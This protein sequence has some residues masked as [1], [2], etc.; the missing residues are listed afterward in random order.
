MSSISPKDVLNN[1]FGYEDFRRGQ[2][3]IIDALLNGTNVLGV[4]PTGSGKSLC[5]QLPSLILEGATIVV[6]PLIALMQDQIDALQKKNI[7]AT[8]I[9]S[10]V[11]RSEQQ[12]RIKL[13]SQGKLDLVY[14]APERFQDER[15]T[16]ALENI[17]VSLL[18]IDEAHCISQ[19]GHDF[20]PDYLEL[21]EIR[22]QLGDPTTIALTATATTLVKDDI[23]TQLSLE[24]PKRVV[25]GFERPNLFFEVYRSQGRR[26]KMQRIR[27]LLEYYHGES[28]LIYCATRSQVDEV[29]TSIQN[30]DYVAAGYHAGLD[31]E[32]RND[33][34]SAFMHGDVPILVATNAFGMGVD[35]PD[36][37]AIVHYNIPGSVEA[38][39][40]EAG[41][42]GR[43]GEHADC[44]LLYDNQDKGIHNFFIDNSFPKRDLVE[45][46]WQKVS[47]K[48]LGEH[49]LSPEQLA[50]KLDRSSNTSSVHS[51]AVETSLKLLKRGGHLDFGNH[52]G[53]PWVNVKTKTR[54]G[55]LRVDW[56]K[57]KRQRQVREDQLQDILY[58][59]KTHGCRQKY[60]LQYFNDSPS[61]RNNCGHCDICSDHPVY[62]EKPPDPRIATERSPETIVKI[63]LSGFAR[64][65]NQHMRRSKL[66]GAAMLR[67][68]GRAA[69]R[70]TEKLSTFGLLDHWSQHKLAQ[71]IDLCHE[72]DLLE[73]TRGD[74]LELTQ[75][76]FE[77]MR[78]DR[79]LP[80]RLRR[81]LEKMG[82]Q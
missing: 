74:S 52:R 43:D 31:N 73:K 1:Q 61:G 51:W 76:G 38:Y 37:R 56:E 62:V 15:F 57:L 67:G 46:V 77:L 26:S 82:L 30:A 16:D 41:R 50:E 21:G 78:G 13:L 10:A 18:A 32:T 40:Q 70:G 2:R 19:W 49:R 28:V 63:V 23:E 29:L 17:A 35:K 8:H 27:R 60:L 75:Q 36:I 48:G 68:S 71:L 12:K 47:A 24:D 9:N 69:D 55:N 53:R 34:Q 39:Y 6:S 7:S 44:V 4:M 22:E 45:R 58:Y 72:S 65:D 64:L 59:A 80:S 3:E 11:S 79:A 20:R 42:A 66:F 14:V 81:R 54:T 33:I 25:S 5:Y